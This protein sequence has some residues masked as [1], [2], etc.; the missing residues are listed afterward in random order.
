MRTEKLIVSCMFW[1]I[2]IVAF[3][4]DPLPLSFEKTPLDE[5]IA[6]FTD[7]SG[8]RVEVP[9]SSNPLISLDRMASDYDEAIE[10][11]A[12]A[13]SLAAVKVGDV[14]RLQNIVR[15]LSV[16]V[17]ELRHREAQQVLDL[18]AKSDTQFGNNVSVIADPETN[19]LI[20]RGSQSE[21]S[22]IKDFIQVFD[23]EVKQILIEAKL[24]SQDVD[25][26]RD[27]GIR[28]SFAT[29][30]AGRS[31]AQGQTIGLGGESGRSAL[32]L[33]FVSDPKL[34]A[35]ELQAL[36]S[37]GVGEVISEPR[38]VTTNRRAATIRQ[39]QQ[40]PFVT[41]DEEGR[42]TTEF[43]DAVLELKVTPVLRDDGRIEM[44]LDIRQDQ[45]GQL[46]T[47]QGPIIETRELNTRVTVDPAET[48]VLG[49][50]YESK[51]ENITVGVPGLSSIPLLG[52]AF[53]SSQRRAFKSELL[54]F[55]TPRVL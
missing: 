43:K 5:V 2:S 27:L 50:I 39:G 22:S 17:V 1:F 46:S 6:M 51:E 25:K 20:L 52:H 42:T 4:S 35:L 48:L 18:L 16:L 7:A 14:Y 49:G 41:V 26:R 47:Q 45:V 24:V 3:A 40:L 33:A 54:I 8:I 44:T 11:I 32:S 13:A 55:I 12:S 21:L 37:S 38:I 28:W 30:E 10:M 34:L 31:G 23:I 53:Q 9:E 36:E 15:N 19:R 29:S